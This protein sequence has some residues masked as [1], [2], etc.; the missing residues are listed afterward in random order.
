MIVK[1]DNL[2]KNNSIYRCDKCNKKIYNNNLVRLSC[3]KHTY[4]LCERCYSIFE[5]WLTS[6]GK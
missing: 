4:H 5:R 6:S 1:I 2:D 3:K